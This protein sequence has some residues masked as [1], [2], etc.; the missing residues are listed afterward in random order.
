MAIFPIRRFGDPV[1]RMPASPVKEIDTG[2]RK[3]VTDMIETM[4]AAPGVGLAAPQ[5]GVSRAVIVFDA[6]DEKGARVLINP[7][8]IESDGEYEYE[9]GCLSVPGHYW[10]ITRPGYV[11]ARGLSLDGEEVEY[12]GEG[13][14]GR[15][16]QHEIDHLRGILLIERL[17]KKVRKQALKSLREEALGLEA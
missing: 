6:Q 9:E 2:V 1:L 14:L 10:P 7:E 8:L 13:L 3:L 11:R 4:Y 16:L 12:F 5:I 17:E 15:V